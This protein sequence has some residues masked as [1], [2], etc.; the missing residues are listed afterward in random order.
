MLCYSI[1]P[2]IQ[3][4]GAELIVSY[5]AE[6]LAQ[7]GHRVSVV[8]T[9]GPEMEPYPTEIRH[10]V[11]VIRFFPKNRYWLFDREGRRG[12]DKLRWHIRDAWN[13]QSGGR[14]REIMANSRPDVVHSHGVEGFSPALWRAA[15]SRRIP[16]V[17]TAHDYYLICPRA[18]LLTR[19]LAICTTPSLACRTRAAWYLRCAAAIDAFCSPSKFLLEKHVA[20]GLPAR[21]QIVVPNGIPV[22]PRQP[23]AFNRT[24]DQPLRLLFAGRLTAEKGLRVLLE[25]MRL[26]GRDCPVLLTIAGKGLLESEAMA[27]AAEDSRISFAGYLSGEEK[28]RAFAAADCLIL[29]SLWYENAPVVVLEAAAFGLPVIGSRLGA[30]P[31]FVEDG[32]NGLLFEPGSAPSLAQAITRIASDRALLESL[33]TGGKPLIAKHSIAAMVD[34]YESVYSDVTRTTAV[35]APPAPVPS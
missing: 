18:M 25:A 17:H 3:A 22:T 24:T 27:A 20:A 7:R 15:Q 12:L 16:I 10:G 2:P 30:I 32:V 5:L 4:G 21:R 6:G 23:K 13:R 1:Y 11:E 9:C 8:S 14:L 28:V 26:I 29:P 35:P 19:R 31:E 34:H 33:A